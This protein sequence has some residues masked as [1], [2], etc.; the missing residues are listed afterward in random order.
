MN[1]IQKNTLTEGTEEGT[2]PS[3]PE[4]NVEKNSVPSAPESNV[5]ENK[6]K[7]NS[8]YELDVHDIMLIAHLECMEQKSIINNNEPD[9]LLFWY[10]CNKDKN[11]VRDSAKQ[12]YLALIAFKKTVHLLVASRGYVGLNLLKTYRAALLVRS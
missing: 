10:V 12:L 7:K 2:A 1:S 4:S 6:I 9:E 8:K 3:A 5:E 11:N